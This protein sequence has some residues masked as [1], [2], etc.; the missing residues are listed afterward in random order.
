MLTT[1]GTDFVKENL[2]TRFEI[3]VLAQ[4]G[5]NLHPAG[6]YYSCNSC[7]ICSFLFVYLFVFL[8]RSL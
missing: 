1:W 4:F 8:V 2:E 7:S 3:C 6:I 5:T